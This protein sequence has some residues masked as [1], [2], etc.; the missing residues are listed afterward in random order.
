M[1]TIAALV[2]STFIIFAQS[3]DSLLVRFDREHD[4]AAKERLLG[5]LTSQEHASGAALLRL[6]QTTTSSDTRW[7]AMRG[8]VTLGYTAAAP[9]LIASLK[10]PDVYVRANAARAIGDLRISGGSREL[11]AMFA[12]E[13]EPAALEQSSLALRLLRIKAAAPL[14]REKIPQFTGQTRG[15]LIQ[16]LGT[17]GGQSDVP[18]IAGYLDET[19]SSFA[20]TEA[21][22]ELTG[23]DFGPH[24]LGLTSIP[25]ARALA[26]KAWW[27]AHKDAWPR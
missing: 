2:L 25:D 9:F 21:L 19:S 16:A 13:H 26:A 20:A 14:V 18:A 3:G 15:W 23:V 17:L 24:P 27:D 12:A 22:Q 1:R 11:L 4:L 10:D 6:A 7:M 8:L 5:A